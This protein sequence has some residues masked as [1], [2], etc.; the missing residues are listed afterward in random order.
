MSRKCTVSNSGLFEYAVDNISTCRPLFRKPVKL[1]K[2][3]QDLAVLLCLLS[4]EVWERPAALDMPCS[5]TGP[6]LGI[7][8]DLHYK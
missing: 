1:R 8:G 5:Q 4:N 6:S 7:D 2:I 3:K